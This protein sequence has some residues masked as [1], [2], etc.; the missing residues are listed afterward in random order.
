MSRTV[1]AANGFATSVLQYFIQIAVQVLLAP[2][3]LKV[4]GRETLGA[5]AAITQAVALLTLVDVAHSWSLERFLGQ[6]ISLG[7]N[8]ERFRKVFTTARTMLLLSNAVFGLL[9]VAFSF[10]V[11]RLFHLSPAI[12]NE[13]RRALY[14]IAIWAVLRTP[15]AAYLNALVASQDLAASNTIGAFLGVARALTS[16][17]FVLAHFGLFGLMLSGSVVEGVGSLLY[18]MR[19]KSLHPTLMPSWGIPDRALFREMIGFGGHAMLLNVG[20]ALM[21]SSANAL[22]GYVGGAAAA[23]SFYTTQ[24]PATTGFNMANRLADNATP[25]IND[26]WGSREIATFRSALFRLL[27]LT[28]AMVLPLAAGVILFNRDVVTAW[29]GERQYAGTLLT[30]AVAAFCVVVPIQRLA[31]IYAF[32]IGWVRLLS[33]TAL[34]QGAGS[35][36]L[37]I[38][39]GRRFGLGGVTLALVIVIVPQTVL[40]WIRLGR[41]LSFE[42]NYVFRTCVLPLLLPVALAF[43]AGWSAS[44]AFRGHGIYSVLAEVTTFI[45]VYGSSAYFLA[46]TAEDKDDIGRYREKL[47]AFYRRKTNPAAA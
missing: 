2:I 30:V 36:L 39:L 10:Y 16:L 17:A 1:R 4:A 14:V 41:S 18:R 13:A 27:R 20:N 21:F 25:A 19:F 28:L 40:L 45:V 37:G 12:E 11:G 6:S 46:L 24:V 47:L 15:L 34:L 38:F 22:A 44:N 23:S 43:G 29:V 7:D 3:V 26:L 42:L 5:Y 35:V 32:V 9:V 31:M 33:V 8:G